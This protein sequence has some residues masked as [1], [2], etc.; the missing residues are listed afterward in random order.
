MLHDRFRL[1]GGDEKIDVMDDLLAPAKTA[2]RLDLVT[3]GMG[4]QR[5]ENHLH[6]G[7]DIAEP[8]ILRVL[9]PELDRLEQLLGGFLSESR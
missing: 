2:R 4:A 9:F 8:E 6:G 1:A 5:V 3:L 7:H